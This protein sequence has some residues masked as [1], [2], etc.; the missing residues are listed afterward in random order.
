MWLFRLLLNTD[1]QNRKGKRWDCMSRLR[2]N[3]DRLNRKGTYCLVLGWIQKG[4]TDME[5]DGTILSQVKNRHQNLQGNRWDLSLNT[6]RQ[7]DRATA[8][9]CLG[10]VWI[11]IGRTDRATD[12]IVW[13]QSKYRQTERKGNSWHCLASAW[14]QIGRKTGQWDCLGSGC[15]QIYCK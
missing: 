9:D 11:Q 14:M 10:S 15:M 3:T 2:L 4:R 7:K 1:R 6:D 5:T 13:P 8:W 12:G